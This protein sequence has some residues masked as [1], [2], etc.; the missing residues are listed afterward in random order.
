[1]ANCDSLNTETFIL[2]MSSLSLTFLC[3]LFTYFLNN[4]YKK[5]DC[6]C[7]YTERD[8]ENEIKEEQIELEKH[9]NYTPSF[10][11]NDTFHVIY[12]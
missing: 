5:L 12:K 1:M 6:L 10:I 8:I 4:K 3:L 2:G 11:Q 7:G 9:I